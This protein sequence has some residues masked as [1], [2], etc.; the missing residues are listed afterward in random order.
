L[1]KDIPD[2]RAVKMHLHKNIPLGAGLGGGSSDG[3]FTLK[4]LDQ[5]FNL[6][7]ST[8]KLSALALQLGSDC[9]FFMINKP[10]FAE[11]GGE[12]LQ[13]ISLDLSAY[14]FILVHPGVHLNTSQAFSRVSPALPKKSVK[15]I[16][17]QPID[18][19]KE[20]LKNDFEESVFA[21]HP[22]IKKIKDDLYKAGA[23]Y[24][25]MTGSGSTVFGIFKKEADPPF[26]LPANYLVKELSGQLH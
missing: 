25:S 23:M 1:K 8:E 11:G 6:G 9:S 22:E 12:L 16:I 21:L 24:A 14:K 19:W 20:E 15:Q 17:Q 7:L 10:C 26:S 13:T 18:T 3:A 4:M 2:L 5:K